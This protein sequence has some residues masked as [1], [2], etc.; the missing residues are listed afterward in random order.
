MYHTLSFVDLAPVEEFNSTYREI[1]AKR[2]GAR[3]IGKLRGQKPQPKPQ[4]AGIF[5]VYN[6]VVNKQ[7]KVPKFGYMGRIKKVADKFQTKTPEMLMKKSKS[8][9]K[10]LVQNEAELKGE[11]VPSV[12]VTREDTL[13]GDL[14][15]DDTLQPGRTSSAMSSMSQNVSRVDFKLPSIVE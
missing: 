14:D 13:E 4:A 15:N 9:N 8:S 7:V 3:A 10:A 6:K 1:Q 5:D 12:T 11:E 2:A